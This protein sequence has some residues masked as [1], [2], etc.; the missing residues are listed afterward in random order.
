MDSGG[1]LQ[2]HLRAAPFKLWA[3]SLHII[4]SSIPV[5]MFVDCTTCL[6]CSKWSCGSDIPL[7]LGKEMLLNFGVMVLVM[8]LVRGVSRTPRAR[9]SNPSVE[10]VARCI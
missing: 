9:S 5:G 1:R 10:V 7:N 2:N 4:S 6:Y 3:K 8:R